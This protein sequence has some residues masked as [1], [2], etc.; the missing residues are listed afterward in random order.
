[1]GKNPNTR[2]H[3]PLRMGRQCVFAHYTPSKIA[4]SNQSVFCS[5]FR[6]KETKNGCETRNFGKNIVGRV[7]ARKA[8]APAI[9]GV[10]HAPPAVNFEPR[11]SLAS[12]ERRRPLSARE[13]PPRFQPHFSRYL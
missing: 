11:T 13:F 8:G 1:M 9:G 2:F 7:H 5:H 6:A 4:A 3:L 12:T 10:F